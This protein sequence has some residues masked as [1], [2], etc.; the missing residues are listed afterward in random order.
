MIFLDYH[1]A[2][3]SC[4]TA[5]SHISFGSFFYL[6]DYWHS[7]LFWEIAVKVVCVLAVLSVEDLFCHCKMFFEIDW[8]PWRITKRGS[9]RGWK[10]WRLFEKGTPC[11]TRGK[12][13]LCRLINKKDAA[14]CSRWRKLIENCLMIRMSVSGSGWMFVLVP[15][16]L[17]SPRQC[18]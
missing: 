8:P 9:T 14:D 11:F 4:Y 3:V 15:A 12:V 17:G 18:H 2:G 10:E 13:H 7:V 16:N 5:F 1:Y 6:F